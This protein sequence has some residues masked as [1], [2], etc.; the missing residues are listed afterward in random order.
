ME[1]VWDLPCWLF[2][3]LNK[4]KNYS[5]ND[6]IIEDQL[7]FSPWIGNDCVQRKR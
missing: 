7:E 6:S 4:M 2:Y 5:T 3:T 1:A